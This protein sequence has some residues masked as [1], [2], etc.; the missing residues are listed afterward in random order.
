MP[1]I[2][3]RKREAKRDML[4]EQPDRPEAERNSKGQFVLGGIGIG[5]RPKGS[6]NDLVEYFIRD[7]C[8]DWQKHG[9]AV[10]IQ[11]RESS[12]VDYLKV[13]AGLLPKDIDVNLNVNHVVLADLPTA[14]EWA[15]EHC[16][17][18]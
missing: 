4:Q 8:E 13:V 6:R 15:A 11:V 14:E 1:T 16:I 2:E 18:H 9:A 10:I 12:P 5:G 17:E 3:R 7:V